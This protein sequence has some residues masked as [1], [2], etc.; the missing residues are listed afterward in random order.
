VTRVA[1]QLYIPPGPDPI[2]FLQP[3]PS[4]CN[5]GSAFSTTDTPA[6]NEPRT[7][8]IMDAFSTQELENRPYHGLPIPAEASMTR[9]NLQNWYA[10]FF[11]QAECVLHQDR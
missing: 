1:R 8:Q 4:V 5:M 7:D 10:V 3:P 11:K 6:D 9:D 2:E